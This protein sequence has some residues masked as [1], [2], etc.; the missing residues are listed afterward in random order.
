MRWTPP[1]ALAVASAVVLLC[2]LG[3]G[4]SVAA[5][6]SVEP[7]GVTEIARLRIA[8][9]VRAKPTPASPQR[10]RLAA[11][12]PVTGQVTAL[13]VLRRATAGGESWV[14]VRLP[15]RP[16]GRVG[17][18]PARNV[19]LIVS[20]W[21]IVV[22]R[23]LRLA[24]VY[25]DGKLVERYPVVVG[26]PATPTPRGSYFVVEHVRQ[27][28]G[29]R[30]GPWALAT[31]AYSHVL[32]EFDGGPGQIALHGRAGDLA[33]DPLG[34]ARSHGCVRF[35]NSVIRRLSKVPNGTPVDIV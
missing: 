14:L 29:S 7:L 17:W 33:R 9:T 1:S 12:R 28:D 32:Q 25:R 13:P 24:L 3:A 6:R 8:T 16:A 15:G 35:D 22:E 30:L 10:G 26:A 2:L 5:S 11:I 19:S 27:Q 34:T 18:I 4:R 21:R 31:S 23:A 20:R